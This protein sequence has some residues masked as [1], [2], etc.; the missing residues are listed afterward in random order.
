[1][2]PLRS[3]TT[4][5]PD[6]SARQTVAHSF[7]PTRNEDGKSMRGVYGIGRSSGAGVPRAS[8]VLSPLPRPGPSHVPEVAEAADAQEQPDREEDVDG[9]VGAAG[10]A[11]VG[12]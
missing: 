8:S 6:S 11:L 12:L 5:R 7:N 3:N 9:V 4:C 1:M 2:P 10:V